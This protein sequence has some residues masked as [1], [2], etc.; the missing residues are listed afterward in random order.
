MRLLTFLVFLFML[1]DLS[2]AQQDS[3]TVHYDNSKLQV[4]EIPDENLAKYREDSDFNY[5]ETDN[6]DSVFT[7]IKW[8][9]YNLLIR[10]L[11]AIFG[12]GKATGIL[13]FILNVLPYLT[14]GV[15]VFLLLKHFLKLNSKNIFSGKQP[16][17]TATILNEEHI[18]KNE[19]INALINK[20]INEGNYRLAIRYYYLLVLKVLTENGTIHW[21]Q[22]KTNEDYINEIK[23]KELQLRFSDITRI[24]DYVWYGEFTINSL[25]FKNLKP[26]FE[27]LT[28]PITKQ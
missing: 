26:A 7:I 14:L 6:S 15:L 16:L 9:L 22:Q 1:P 13:R 19:D 20:A 4:Q 3:L 28:K 17:S 25:K 8:W 24:Y 23:N 5:V 21:E 2:L 10:I 12:V 18:I 27:I 11:E